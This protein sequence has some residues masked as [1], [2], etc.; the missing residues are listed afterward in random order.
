MKKTNVSIIADDLGNVIRESKNPKYGHIRLEQVKVTFPRGFMKRKV[1]SALINGEMEELKTLGWNAG[2]QSLNFGAIQTIEQLEP[3]NTNDADRDLKYAGNTGVICM[4]NDS[5]IYRKTM[6]T[7]D[8]N[9]V[10]TLIAHTNADDIR[11][12]NG[13]ESMVDAKTLTKASD[14]GLNTDDAVVVE[15]EVVE[16]VVEELAPKL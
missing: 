15:E 4:H 12:A 14:F 2:A 13:T 9:A 8:I 3:F 5:P 11:N 16:D 10:D 7:E 1:V 6:F